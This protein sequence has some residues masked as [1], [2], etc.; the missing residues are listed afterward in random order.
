M[1]A[2]NVR[3]AAALVDSTPPANRRSNKKLR[4]TIDE[5]RMQT[6]AMNGAAPR[7][8]GMFPLVIRHS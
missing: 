1:A 4:I 6:N 3:T 8:G 7:S 2:E 5:L